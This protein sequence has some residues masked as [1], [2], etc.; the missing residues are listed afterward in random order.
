M[1]SADGVK[2]SILYIGVN[3]SYNPN[4]DDVFIQSD[5]HLSLM[6]GSFYQRED[7]PEYFN[8]LEE[9]ASMLG[10]GYTHINLLYARE[11]DRDALIHSNSDFIREQLELTYETIIK[12][13]PVA[14]IFFSDYCRDMIFGADRWVDPIS[15]KDGHYILR[16]TCIPIFFSDDITAINDTK[17]MSL[18]RKI[19][20]VL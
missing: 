12:I 13:K 18:M 6:Y 1:F 3:P 5:D 16:G 8:I 15:E 10:K 9:F 19:K 4:D 7:A 20:T 11:N 2:D 17:K 14:I